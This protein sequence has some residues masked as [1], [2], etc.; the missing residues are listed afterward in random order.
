MPDLLVSKLMRYLKQVTFTLFNAAY[1]LLCRVNEGSRDTLL[2]QPHSTR[3]LRNEI[4]TFLGNFLLTTDRGTIYH[5]VTRMRSGASHFLAVCRSGIEAVP[6]FK[7]RERGK[8]GR[9]EVTTRL[10]QL[11]ARSRKKRAAHVDGLEINV[12]RRRRKKGKR[13]RRRRRRTAIDGGLEKRERRRGSGR[14]SA[15]K[16]AA[17]VAGSLHRRNNRTAG[18]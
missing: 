1:I 7:T 16:S 5:R 13:R 12:S 3:L 14:R 9:K 10:L 2:Q 15:I 4:K 18:E 17:P 11:S 6:R 8:E